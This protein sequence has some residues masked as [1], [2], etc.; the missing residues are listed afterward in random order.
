MKDFEH[1]KCY[2]NHVM[3]CNELCHEGINIPIIC[4][5]SDEVSG[6]TGKLENQLSTNCSRLSKDEWWYLVDTLEKWRVF[7]PRAIV[8][9]DPQAAW[10]CMNLCKD[11]GVRVPGAYFTACFRTELALKNFKKTIG[12]A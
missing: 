5:D 9:K 3:T 10:K 12:A 8:K 2:D 1:E 7:N 6:K 4:H 11:K